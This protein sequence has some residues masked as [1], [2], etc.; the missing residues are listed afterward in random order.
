MIR[1]SLIPCVDPPYGLR[2]R[3]HWQGRA[4]PRSWRATW[5]SLCTRQTSSTSTSSITLTSLTQSE[6]VEPTHRQLHRTDYSTTG[7]SDYSSASSSSPTIGEAVLLL[8]SLFFRD[9]CKIAKSDYYSGRVCQYVRM[10][11]LG[12]HEADFHKIWYS[13]SL[14]RSCRELKY[15]GYFNNCNFS[16]HE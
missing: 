12:P 11:N 8:I 3:M 14:R 13:S 5:T 7:Q 15:I 9:L 4:V 10:E 2:G 6:A 16:K 1:D